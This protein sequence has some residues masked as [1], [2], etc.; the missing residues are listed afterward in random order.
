[1]E[2]IIGLKLIFYSSFTQ[3][4]FRFQILKMMYE[5]KSSLLALEHTFKASFNS[6]FFNF[7]LNCGQFFIDKLFSKFQFIY[8]QQFFKILIVKLTPLLHRIFELSN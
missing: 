3:S 4:T 6:D 2:H 1:M 8:V 5:L 7:S